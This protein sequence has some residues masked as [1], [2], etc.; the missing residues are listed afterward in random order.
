MKLLI[1]Y[2]LI[3]ST[4]LHLQSATQ[5]KQNSHKLKTFISEQNSQLYLNTQFLIFRLVILDGNI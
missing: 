5:Q 3:W 4:L 1:I 2:E